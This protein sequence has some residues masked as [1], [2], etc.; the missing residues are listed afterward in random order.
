[1]CSWWPA[2]GWSESMLS[3]AWRINITVPLTPTFG[4]NF[5][6]SVAPAERPSYRC[7]HPRPNLL[8]SCPNAGFN[9]RPCVSRLHLECRAGSI[10]A[11]PSRAGRLEQFLAHGFARLVSILARPSR[12]GRLVSR[13]ALSHRTKFLALREP[14][15]TSPKRGAA[16][17]PTPAFGKQN[18]I[19]A[20]A[21]NLPA[22]PRH[23]RSARHSTSGPS[24]STALN[25]PYSR[26]CSSTGS[27]RR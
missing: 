20:V 27:V 23:L 4:I 11:R 16:N 1:M 9:P 26:T 10:L 7:F 18:Q 14:S 22:I 24:K 3:V 2:P 15:S 21:A 19:L 13:I 17:S 5:R 6:R 12:A 8:T 25:F